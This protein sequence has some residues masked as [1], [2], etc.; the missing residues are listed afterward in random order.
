[1]CG[2]V[3]VVAK[4]P[5]NQVLSESVVHQYLIYTGSA[6]LAMPDHIRHPDWYYHYHVIDMSTLDYERF[7]AVDSPGALV[8]AILCDFRGHPTRDV[9]HR[10]ISRL[11]EKLIDTPDQLRNHLSMLEL[12]SVNRDFADLFKTVEAEM[13]SNIA[14]NQLP[15]YQIGMERGWQSGIESGMEQGE[16]KAAHLIAERLQQAGCSA[17]LIAQTTGLAPQDVSQ[18]A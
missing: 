12:L 13:L 4:T 15:S 9:L 10:I 18:P 2:L 17:E 7:M 14:L 5:A 3:G 1:M 6:R 11:T 16:Q 8:L